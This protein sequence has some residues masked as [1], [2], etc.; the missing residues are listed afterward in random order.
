MLNKNSVT[1]DKQCDS[2]SFWLQYR[3]FFILCLCAG[4]LFYKYI[5]QV[6][7]SVITDDL[8]R[9]YHLTATGLG[10]LAATFYYS[11]MIMQ[12]VV[13]MLIDKYGSRILTGLSI[14]ICGIA[15]V[16]FTQA[17][18]I[19]T[20]LFARTLMGIGVAFATVTYLKL[21]AIWFQPRYYAVLSGLL[22][23]AAMA[24]AVFGEAPLRISIDI[25]GW[26]PTMNIVGWFGILMGFLFLL[27]VRDYV[28]KTSSKED[29]ATIQSDSLSL[30]TILSVFKSWQNWFLTA[31]TGLAFSPIAVFGGLWGTPFIQTAWDIS[32]TEAASFVS[33][34]FIG[35]GLG[36]PILGLLGARFSKR[37]Q[38]LGVCKVLSALCLASVLYFHLPIWLLA[39]QLFLFGFFAGS[40]M[41]GFT[42]GK[43]INPV[44]LTATVIAM[45]N[46]SE[47]IIDAFTEPTIGKLL[48]LQWHGQIV[49]GFHYFSANAY[50]IALSLLPVYL[51]LA[52]IL[53]FF[54]IKDKGPVNSKT[55]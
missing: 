48:D 5:L 40:F 53:M 31:Y 20:V 54:F 43:E 32:K 41:L 28:S 47:P 37:L 29:I 16:L 52:A 27:I 39:I 15:T 22:A 19:N 9:D 24:G 10:N 50:E 44:F 46:A 14:L 18:S 17:H 49:N 30:N 33:L 6:F 4:F 35:L 8:M 51:I 25:F 45:L 42:I 26:R 55:G 7:P 21:A 13:G 23:T 1:L 36:S 11:Y 12:L 2:K 38:F 34:S 3:A